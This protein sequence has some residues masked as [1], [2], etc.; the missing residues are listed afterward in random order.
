MGT[1]CRT[2]HCAW[3]TDVRRTCRRRLVSDHANSEFLR[4]FQLGATD[5]IKVEVDGCNQALP[6]TDASPCRCGQPQGHVQTLLNMVEF[7][8][9]SQEALDAPRFCIPSGTANGAVCLEY[10]IPLE[11]VDELRRRGHD[12]WIAC[13]LRPGVLLSERVG[14]RTC[15]RPPL[16]PLRV[17]N[18][19]AIDYGID[20]LSLRG[21]VARPCRNSAIVWFMVLHSPMLVQK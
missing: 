14:C 8:M 17:I 4:S 19:C 11:V 6:G 10:G 7:G 13:L 1:V 12:V 21:V 20:S 9:D 5:F 3:S 15:H 16:P 18:G 2:R